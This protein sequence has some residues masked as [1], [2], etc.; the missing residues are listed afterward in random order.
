M[1]VDMAAAWEN[2]GMVVTSVIQNQLKGR[3]AGHVEEIGTRRRSQGVRSSAVPASTPSPGRIDGLCLKHWFRV[4]N[5]PI[6]Y[7]E[8]GGQTLFPTYGASGGLVGQHD[9]LSLDGR[10]HRQ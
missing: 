1:N 4:E 9:V 5:Q 8:V 10:E 7:Y 6:D 3:V 2:V